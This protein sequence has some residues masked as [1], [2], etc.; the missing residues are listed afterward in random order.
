MGAPF[1]RWTARLQAAAD[2]DAQRGLLAELAMWRAQRLTDVPASREATFAISRLHMLLG[3]RDDAVREARSLLSLC[4]TPPEATAEEHQAARAY[5]ESLGETAPPRRKPV[6]AA[7]PRERRPRNEAPTGGPGQVLPLV[8]RG[9]F[10]EALRALRGQKGARAD[11]VRAYV[12]L[13]RALA[14]DDPQARDRDLHD[15][16][17]R[18]ARFAGARGTAPVSQEREAEPADDPLSRLLGAP[19]PRRRDARVRALE[20]FA[21]A[22]PD[23]VDELAATALRQHVVRSGLKAPA[24]WLAGT[25]GRALA[26][27]PATQ[28]RAALNELTDR[29]SFAVTAY[30]EWPFS[31]LL[32]VATRALEDGWTYGGMR[33]GSG[34]RNEPS[35]RKL[36]TLRLGRGGVERVLVVGAHTSD[37]YPGQVAAGLGAH[38]AKLGGAVALLATGA[39]NAALRDAAAPAGVTVLQEDGDDAS[40]LSALEAI[41]ARPAQQAPSASARPAP[42]G[43]RPREGLEAAL[44]D[45]SENSLREAVER[46]GRPFRAVRAAERMLEFANDA[47]IAQLLAIAHELQGD[48]GPIPEGTT[49]GVRV[50]SGGGTDTA[51]VLLE[52]PTAERFGG[53]GM[54]VVIELGAALR[55]DGWEVFRVLRGPTRKEQDAHPA[56][57]TLAD[58]LGG[59][60]RLLV[61]RDG[62]KGEV[63]YIAG[64]SAEGRAGVPQLL[65]ADYPR[66]VVLPIDPDLLGWYET[67]GGPAPIGWTGEEAD[68]VRAAAAEWVAPPSAP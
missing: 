61:R 12:Q 17:Q 28:T 33:R 19:V 39:G 8:E 2:A 42:E 29:G 45:P 68:A 49:L 3:D 38:L 56:L 36:W 59:L 66:S 64:L 9:A 16:H 13:S 52:G 10:G 20:Q 55:A 37:P 31:R 53:A 23:R 34:A 54:D 50:A 58:E 57:A 60:W 7:A 51:R 5:L 4:Q 25:V 15:L 18:L 11:L 32:R 14:A 46:F 27:G 62:A 35:D 67:L 48:R 41:E 63:W 26:S 1:E 21:Q 40:L 65:L 43:P 24:P 47:A 22:N 30:D 44:R 6:R